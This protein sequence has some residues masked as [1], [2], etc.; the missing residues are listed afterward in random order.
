MQGQTSV[1]REEIVRALFAATACCSAVGSFI[2]GRSFIRKLRLENAALTE[3][4]LR[5]E[6]RNKQLDALYNVFCEITE[7]LS[8]SH[9]VQ[10]ALRETMQLMNAHGAVMVAKGKAACSGGQPDERRE[11]CPRNRGSPARRRS[12]GPHSKARTDSEDR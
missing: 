6:N 7:T 5:L 8:L 9:V 3:A 10:A 2:V 1:S 12:A 11:A 4:K